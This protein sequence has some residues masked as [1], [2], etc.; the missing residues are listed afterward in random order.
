MRGMER[1]HEGENGEREKGEKTGRGDRERR[2][3]GGDR[4]RREGGKEGGERGSGDRERCLLESLLTISHIYDSRNLVYVSDHI[5]LVA[6][7]NNMI[8]QV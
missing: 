2:E 1:K 5:L 4:E 6:L 7:N 8:L 3:G